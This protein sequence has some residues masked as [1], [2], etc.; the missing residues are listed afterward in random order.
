MFLERL[1]AFL[2]YSLRRI[3]LHLT[4]EREAAFATILERV[5]THR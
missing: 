1:P 5:L 4:A 2:E 3:E